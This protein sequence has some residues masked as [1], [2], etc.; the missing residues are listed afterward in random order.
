METPAVVEQN[1][2]SRLQCFLH[3]ML[4]VTF[5][6]HHLWLANMEVHAALRMLEAPDKLQCQ[7]KF[8]GNKQDIYIFL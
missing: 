6:C 3:I 8:L 2:Y 4:M 5:N 1:E 7:Y